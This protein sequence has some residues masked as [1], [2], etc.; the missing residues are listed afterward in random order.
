MMSSIGV[1]VTPLTNWIVPAPPAARATPASPS[2]CP[3]ARKPTL[4]RRSR[5]GANTAARG[6]NMT[7][8]KARSFSSMVALEP[9]PASN[10]WNTPFGRRRAASSRAS[11]TDSIFAAA[12]TST[13]LMLVLS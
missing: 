9:L 2:R 7:S 3:T 6:R 1:L 12:L 5:C 13:R 11:S 8:R 4:V 10:I